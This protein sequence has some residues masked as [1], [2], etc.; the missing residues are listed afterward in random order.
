M[1]SKNIAALALACALWASPAASRESTLRNPTSRDCQDE[2]LRLAT[3]APGPV[4]SFVVREDGQ[5]IPYFVESLGGTNWIW[6]LTD[7]PA[8]TV[9]KYEVVPGR[10]APARR[11]V[12]VKKEGSHYLLDNGRIAVKLPAEAVGEAPGPIASVRLGK[13]WVGGSAWKVSTRLQ[14]FTAA[15]VAD[16]AVLGKVRLHY[17]FDG[18][19]GIDRHIPAFAEVDVSLGPG[20]SHAELFERHEMAQDD[21]WEF[22]ASK[23]WAPRQGSSEPFGGGFGSPPPAKTRPLVPIVHTAFRDDLFITLWPRW[24][25]GCKNGWFFAVH[26]GFAAVAALAVRPGRWVWP[27]QNG[28]EVIVKASGNYA[29]FRAPTWRGQRLWWLL[30]GPQETSEPNRDYIMR[31]S[32]ECLDK[33]NHELISNWPGK[34]GVFAGG[35]SF[36]GI[37]P[38]GG[39]RGEGRRAVAE[40]G[41]AGDYAALV[42]CQSMMH[43]DM[44][45]SY[46]DYWSPE[47]PNFFT[48]FVRVPIALA[49]QLKAHPRFKEIAQQ[50]EM[51]FRED[52]YH[53]VTLPGGAGQECPGYLGH[54]L[55]AWEALAPLAREHLGFDPTTWD[56][57]HAAR[58]F[59]RRI[60]QPDGQERLWLHMGDTHPAYWKIDVPAD[61]VAR[62]K[63]EELPGFGVIFNNRPG[64][65]QETYLAF[66]SGPNRGH[67][68][69]DQL[70][71]H[72]CADARPLAVDHHCSY[73]PRAGQEHMHNR[74]AF[75]TDKFAWANM[76][77]Y[78]RLIAFKTSKDV[79]IAVGQ[80]ES[81][82]LR[83]TT[84]KPPEV[85]HQEYPQLRFEKPLCYRRT[86][87]FL[88]NGPRDYFVLRDQFWAPQA[89]QATYCLHVLSE[90]IARRGPRVDFGNLTLYCAEPAEFEFASFPW[91]HKNGPTEATQGARLSIQADYG[92]FVTILYPGTAPAI[93][94]IPGGVKVGDDEITFSCDEPAAGDASTYVTV[95]RGEQ[96]AVMLAG[97]DLDLDR[98]Q[99]EVGLF[100]PDAG[101]PFGEIPDWLIRQRAK[102]PDWAK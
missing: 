59:L 12:T 84:E 102:R 10:P 11:K 3:P 25:Q 44:Y 33:L 32:F 82:R 28:I 45:G 8:G 65:S 27:H 61:E 15:I 58:R 74:L 101:Y 63:T 26:D 2:V 77:G 67:Y 53:S 57:F 40:A 5:E 37:N 17:D 48:D 42:R 54:A 31:Y 35:W 92:Q 88:K 51:K 34:Q 56:R 36:G 70:A 73:A 46:W 30:A 96:A 94:T 43:P 85:W 16:G 13:Q 97:K 87:V 23:G 22:E 83:A 1:V 18:M 4:G 98:S 7:L 41:K 55:E 89:L 100:V 24:N 99:G 69:G 6:V 64:T 60:S 62:F 75:S 81:D 29:G 49:A 78:E 38:T 90:K 79:D 20:W 39:L 93:T 72:Y 76:D 80:V 9:K 68:H 86:V 47:N 21:S 91:Q 19:A 95:K 52:L 66:K 71:F 50:A 14:K